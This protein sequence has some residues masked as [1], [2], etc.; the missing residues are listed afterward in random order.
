VLPFLSTTSCQPSP[1]S[2]FTAGKMQCYRGGS[3][4]INALCLGRC[5]ARCGKCKCYVPI[6][7]MKK[8]VTVIVEELP[9]SSLEE[10]IKRLSTWGFASVRVKTCE[11]KRRLAYCG[12]RSCVRQ[13]PLCCADSF[14][15]TSNQFLSSIEGLPS[16]HSRTRTQGLPYAV[17]R[18][19]R[20]RSRGR[21]IGD[22][23]Q[24]IR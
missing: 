23:I 13:P 10:K 11:G 19:T 16:S 15:P 18:Q 14:Q 24:R 17:S 7:R 8:L 1:F 4:S 5:I 22:S 9:T 2:F 21:C 6:S 20:Q 3:Q 12:S